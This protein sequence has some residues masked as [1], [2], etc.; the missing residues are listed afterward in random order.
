[1]IDSLTLSVLIW[2]FTFFS[3]YFQER[4]FGI[5][6]ALFKTLLEM[7]AP[8]ELLKV[9]INSTEVRIII[10]GNG[11]WKEKGRGSKGCRGEPVKLRIDD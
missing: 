5:L 8:G 7:K 11:D 3:N 4:F 2:F 10:I 6:K 1:M 9:G